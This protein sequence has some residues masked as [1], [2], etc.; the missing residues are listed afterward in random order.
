MAPQPLNTLQSLLNDALAETPPG[1]SI[2]VA[3]SGGLDSCLLL[4]LAAK[5]CEQADRHLRAIHI[6]H[7]L[8]AAAQTFEAHCRAMCV[9]VNVPLTV[10]NVAVNTQGKGIEGAA[11]TA[12]YEA[13]FATIPAGD[14]LWLAQHQDD[15]AETFLLAALRGSGPRG[16]AGM[17]YRREAQS[18][19]LVRP[20]LSVC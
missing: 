17:P 12:R 11:R 8:Q 4:A 1:R 16:L 2:W 6:N 7:G 13:F 5:V 14:T 10:V 3:L 19:A 18:A 20:W 15:Q 9:R